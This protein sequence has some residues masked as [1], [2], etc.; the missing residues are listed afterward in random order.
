M[1]R[2]REIQEKLNL[3]A[4]LQESFANTTGKVLGWLD[5]DIRGEGMEANNMNAS[6]AAFF[7]LPVMQTGSGLNLSHNITE[8]E[9]HG[10]IHTI[11]EFIKSDKKVNSLS[12]KKQRS[13]PK[14]QVNSIYRISKEDT[15]AMVSLKRKMRKVQK[16]DGMQQLRPTTEQD[17]SSNSNAKYSSESDDEPQV[18]KAT[19]KKFG[20]LFSAKKKQRK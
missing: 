13:Q 6:K 11:G 3:Q 2:A 17:H 12:K 15:K 19:K 1:S 8:P 5:A 16:E 18:E 20:L 7:Q 10:D 9:D 14:T 4:K